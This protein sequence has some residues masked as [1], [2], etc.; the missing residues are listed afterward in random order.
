MVTLTVQELEVLTPEEK[1]AHLAAEEVTTFGTG[2]KRDRDGAPI[3]QGIGSPGRETKNHLQ[4]IRRYE[5]E[6]AYAK[7]VADIKRRDPERAKKLG[8]AP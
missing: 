3:E 8:L 1:A 4:S 5:G 7:V 2:F 6:E